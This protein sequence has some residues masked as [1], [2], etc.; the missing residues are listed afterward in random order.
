MNPIGFQTVKYRKIEEILKYAIEKE[1]SAFEIF[2]DGFLPRDISHSFIEI[3]NNYRCSNKLFFTV[4]A[5]IIQIDETHWIDIMKE[6]LVFSKNVNAKYLTIHAEA[7]EELFLSKLHPLLEL[8]LE[9]YK[10]MKLCLENTPYISCEKMNKILD[11]L[12]I[13]PNVGITFDIGHAQ[14]AYIN[15]SISIKNA[16]LFLKELEGSIF[17]CHLHNN[18][19]ISDSHLSITNRA[20]VINIKEILRELITKKEFCGPFI[21]E[22]FRGDINMDLNFLRNITKC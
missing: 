21:F 14:L 9:K 20:G 22:Y 12:K 15:Q 1:L 18:D 10:R 7:R 4:H 11:K 3:L 17:E 2:F 6:T 5:P 13:F 16:F 8:C 19:G